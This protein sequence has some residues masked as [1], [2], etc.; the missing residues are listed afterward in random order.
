MVLGPLG[1]DDEGLIIN[2]KEGAINF[3]ILRAHH[4]LGLA[5][6]ILPSSILYSL[7]KI[8]INPLRHFPTLAILLNI[9]SLPSPRIK[10]T[11]INIADMDHLFY[12]QHFE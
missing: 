3:S 6:V 11:Q 9:P 12:Q 5:E 4:Q 10:P 8:A 7:I 2:E 1:V